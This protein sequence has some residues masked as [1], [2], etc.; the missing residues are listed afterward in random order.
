MLL[1]ILFHVFLCYSFTFRSR[2]VKGITVYRMYLKDDKEVN[3]GLCKHGNVLLEAGCCWGEVM[4][5][6]VSMEKYHKSWES[7]FQD[8]KYFIKKINLK[9]I[10]FLNEACRECMGPPWNKTPVPSA[11]SLCLIRGCHRN[12]QGQMAEI[13]SC[14]SQE[15]GTLILKGD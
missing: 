8:R 2:K 9:K 3:R 10:I 15:L 1:F 7:L 11:G 6:I 14:Q 13:L 5:E 12:Q 4:S